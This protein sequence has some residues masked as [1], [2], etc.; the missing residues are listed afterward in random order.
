M[1]R[2]EAAGPNPNELSSLG[3]LHQFENV[4]SAPS[5]VTLESCAVVVDSVLTIA[6]AEG[7]AQYPLRKRISS[8]TSKTQNSTLPVRQRQHSNNDS[9]NVPTSNISFMDCSAAFIH[10][11]VAPRVVLLLAIVLSAFLKFDHFSNALLLNC[12][13]TL[14]VSVTSLPPLLPTSAT[15][16][17]DMLNRTHATVKKMYEYYFAAVCLGSAPQ[18]LFELKTAP[19]TLR[20][21]A[22][23]FDWPLINI[24]PLFCSNVYIFFNALTLILSLSRR[25]AQF[26]GYLA[27]LFMVINLP[28]LSSAQSTPTCSKGTY[29]CQSSIYTIPYRGKTSGSGHLS[30]GTYHLSNQNVNVRFSAKG[31]MNDPPPGDQEWAAVTIEGSVAITI[32]GGSGATCSTWKSI[33]QVLTAAQ[34]NSMYGNNN[35]LDFTIT[36][37]DNLSDDCP[38]SGGCS[39]PCADYNQMRMMMCQVCPPGKITASNGLNACTA[40]SS[41]TF[42][43]STGLSQCSAC[44]AGTIASSTG[45][46]QCSACLAGTIASSTGLSQ[47]SACLAGTIAS[48]TG[49]SACSACLAGTI[50]ASAGLSQC[51]T[52]TSPNFASTSGMAGG[53]Q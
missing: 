4:S 31:D 40:C 30:C 52:C 35:Q 26:A 32:T 45:L 16:L 38:S 51:T 48:S 11:S 13:P 2:S 24:W 41:G 7:E 37:G 42:A 15:S 10:E 20:R 44:L 34:Y 39:N 8:G 1:S 12:E 14:A 21:H 18:V 6:H 23:P 17:Q 50:A 53:S 33:D 46:S 22:V 27:V 36:A 49:R 5:S 29:L 28:V 47:C 3:F 9:S 25:V 19:Q 43:A